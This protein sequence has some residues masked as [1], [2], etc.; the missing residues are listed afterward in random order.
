MPKR[1]RT[2]DAP[3]AASSAGDDIG[4]SLVE[5]VSP[6]TPSDANTSPSPDSPITPS[7]PRPARTDRSAPPIPP[8]GGDLRDVPA[9]DR[10]ARRRTPT[11]PTNGPTS[12]RKRGIEPEPRAEAR[13]PASGA[14]TSGSLRQGLR[15]GA[16]ALVRARGNTLFLQTS[17]ASGSAGAAG[18]WGTR[19]AR[20]ATRRVVDHLLQADRAP[21]WPRARHPPA[22][23]ARR[24][25]APPIRCRP[26]R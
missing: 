12:A 7:R 26:S 8:F 23:C 22:A 4:R 11:K 1:D 17:N 3:P 20:V 14:S 16:Q 5:R 13:A 10:R 9:V 6:R 19:R 2:A 15:R 25:S 21:R 24:P 18:V